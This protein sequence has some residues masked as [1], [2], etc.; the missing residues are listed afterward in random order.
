M[1]RHRYCSENWYTV[2]LEVSTK[3]LFRCFRALFASSSDIKPTK[4]NFRNLPSLVNLREQSV[5]VP[6][7]ANI[8]LNLSSFICRKHSR[9]QVAKM[10]L[11]L[12]DDEICSDNLPHSEDFLR[13]VLTLLKFM[14]QSRY[15]LILVFQFMSTKTHGQ[16]T[17]SPLL[18]VGGAFLLRLDF[19]SYLGVWSPPAGHS[20]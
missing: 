14:L 1:R 11:P 10:N 17:T 19:Y 4:P 13:W 9:L 12:Q 5:T 16:S 18:Y 7:A 3:L 8:D 20:M 2:T 15:K 6:N